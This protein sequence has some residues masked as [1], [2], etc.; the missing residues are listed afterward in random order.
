MYMRNNTK[1]DVVLVCGICVCGGMWW[2]SG[3]AI[4]G[5]YGYDRA[6]WF[7]A[8]LVSIVALICARMRSTSHT[9]QLPLLTAG[10]LVLVVVF[11]RQWVQLVHFEADITDAFYANDTS[12]FRYCYHELPMWICGWSYLVVA[13]IPACL[14]A[15]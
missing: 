11:V 2:Q 5:A 12:L 15:R 6:V 10:V 3:Y 4:D 7:S 14:C 1:N 9:V 8:L 13:T